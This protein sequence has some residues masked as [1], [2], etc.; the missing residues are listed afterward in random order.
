MT[1]ATLTAADMPVSRQRDRYQ[2]AVTLFVA[3]FIFCGA[4]SLI[5]PSPYDLAALMALPLWMLGGFRVNKFIIV[6]AV[7]W[8][9]REIAA[10]A[11]L[12]PYWNEPDPR[13]FQFQSLYLYVTVIFFTIFFA[14]RT[15]ERTDAALRA[16]AASTV[17]SAT[18]AI[19]SYLNLFGLD[20]LTTIEGR[21]AGTFKDP[22]VFGSYLTLGAV[23]FLHSLLVGRARFPILSALSLGLVLTGVFLSFSRGSWGATIFAM[24]LTAG[25]AFVTHRDPKMRRRIILTAFAGF[26]ILAL[27]L[28]IALS[29]DSIREFFLQRAKLE[30]EYDGGVT[31]RFGNQIRSLPMLLDRPMGFGPLRFR[32]VFDLEPHNSYI[33]A[34][35][36]GGWLGGFSWIAI[37]AASVFVGFRLMFRA[38][39]FR[40][41]A[42]MV[43]PALLALLLQGF[44]I[45]IDHWRQLFLM[46]GLLWGLEAA[47]RR[48]I[49]AGRPPSAARAA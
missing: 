16:Y 1:F 38:S 49:S 35:A 47:R 23:I 25:V 42:Q 9:I 10:F 29:Q 32:L 24:V 7:A 37:V 21:V 15:Q 22:N 19:M 11:A 31:G 5:E 41:F 14:E 34:F 20:A 39:P 3:I 44:Q 28:L 13:L 36:N 48:W 4:I 33:G 27:V 30:Q 43:F 46:F 8:T 26:V 17:L 40:D 18:V 2:K 6:L 45:D 12:M